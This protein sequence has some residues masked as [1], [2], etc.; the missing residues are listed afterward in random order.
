MNLI[1][2]ILF[3]SVV[4]IVLIILQFSIGK[5]LITKLLPKE[6]SGPSEETQ[7]RGFSVIGFIGTP[8]TNPG[9]TTLVQVEIIGDPGYSQTAVMV[10]ESALCLALNR[11]ELADGGVLTPAAAFGD[12][13]VRRLEKAGITIKPVDR[14]DKQGFFDRRNARINS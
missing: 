9:D 13:I 7:R 10:S 11:K 6:G 1:F 5:K 8:E 3:F 14:F 2:G 4:F 12:V